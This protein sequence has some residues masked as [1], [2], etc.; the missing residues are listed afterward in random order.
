MPSPQQNEKWTRATAERA[1]AVLKKLANLRFLTINVG[2]TTG[3]SREIADMMRRRN[4]GIACIQETR[5]KGSKA[6]EIGDGYKMY[7][8]LYYR[9][10]GRIRS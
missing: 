2:T 3:K 1:T 4:I 8:I 10:N 6:R 9:R 7:I 5:W